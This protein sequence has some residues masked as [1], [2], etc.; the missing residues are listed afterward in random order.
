MVID[1]CPSCPLPDCDDR[2]P[3]CGL[4]KATRL[5]A[6]YYRRGLDIP[7]DVQK[8][9]THAYNQLYAEARARSTAKWTRKRSE[10][11]RQRREALA[12]HP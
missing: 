10:L 4:R 12:N 5:R 7:P 3:E 1:P 8:A 9:A 11:R 6:W 2:H